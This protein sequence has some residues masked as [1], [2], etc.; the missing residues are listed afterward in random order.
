MH[1]MSRPLQGQMKTETM[2]NENMNMIPS[3]LA[4][5]CIDKYL[6]EI[7]IFEK[8]ASLI[9]LMGY[10]YSNRDNA[11]V[12]VI[13]KLPTN[14]GA[15]HHLFQGHLF[16]DENLD[17]LLTEYDAV[18]SY[19]YRRMK[20]IKFQDL[21]AKDMSIP[22]DVVNLC[23]EA[24][25]CK[26]G[27][28]VY[29]PFAGECEFAHSLSKC[30][31]EGFVTSGSMWAIQQIVLDATQNNANISLSD[32]STP[33]FVD[34][35]KKYDFIFSM[36]DYLSVTNVKYAERAFIDLL[37]N[38]L[39]N[40]GVM[41]VIVPSSV[42][43]NKQWRTF[44]QYI[45]DWADKYSLA[46][47]TLP[48][49][50]LPNLDLAVSILIIQKKKSINGKVL[51]VNANHPDM[52]IVDKV[53]Y[54]KTLKVNSILESV[55]K[56]DKR[57]S[58]YVSFSDLGK[59]ILFAAERYFV[60]EAIRKAKSGEQKFKVGDLVDVINPIQRI[61]A[62]KQGKVVRMRE[63]SD[64][65]LKSEIILGELPEADIDNGYI[66]MVSDGC[67]AGFIGG[68]FKVGYLPISN[69]TIFLKR[70][71]VQFRVKQ[72]STVSK[73]YL[74]R[75]LMSDYV[76]KQAERLSS[77][78]TIS[79][80][81]VEDFLSLVILVPDRD[82]QDSLVFAD[83][84]AGLSAQDRERIKAAADFRKDVHMKKHAI[85]QTI[86]NLGNWLNNLAYAREVGNGVIDDKTE[87]GGLVKIKVSD[88]FDNINSAM[89]VLTHQIQTFDVSY[90]M[91]SENFSLADFLD[92]Y[93]ASHQ[94]SRVLYDFDSS[95]DRFKQDLPFI[96]FDDTDPNPAN[97]KEILHPGKYI[98]K[99]GDPITYIE[100]PKEALTI[101]LDNIIS[102]A[103]SHG[104]T[105]PDK[106]Y[107]IRFRYESKGS[108]VVLSISN[109]GAP[110]AL[111]RDPENIFVYGETSGDSRNHY[112][113][114]GYQV[115]S[116]MK[117]FDGD[118]EIVST[119]NEEF[120]VTYN[121]IFGKTNIV[122]VL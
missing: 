108:S 63:L 113:I 102:N 64:N 12:D 48:R 43:N 40:D 32:T 75:E 58:R 85:G 103:V 66:P 60:D 94:H 38:K 87:I 33:E 114:G 11:R 24:V 30:N 18:I 67:L 3:P 25:E 73:D 93:L 39:I 71:I 74:L 115:K 61:N 100:F 41:C 72:N 88:I 55:E 57:F 29:L 95:L 37:E 81:S 36:P 8:E 111:E 6:S 56:G 54:K 13:D 89:N 122:E 47:I 9:A 42:T 26:D 68:K 118:A 86:F 116:L 16:N 99:V 51:M 104:F 84:L 117:E 82:V 120:T 92:D 7:S 97:W 10:L 4:K 20:S 79:R 105:C 44:R 5:E 34:L 65:Y 15:L 31:C 106:E 110:L 50:I 19:C 35:G 53:H 27:A 28:S 62:I 109:N 45:I 121:L 14:D 76:Q 80:I 69:E 96:E 107:T 21:N 112:G 91:K 49:Y 2:V 83:G 23:I 59:D 98:G 78:M 17:I 1:S 90:G 70:D 52:Y 46:S 22:D 77:G 119:P 101:I